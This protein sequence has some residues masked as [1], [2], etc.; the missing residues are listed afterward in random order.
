[1]SEA[2]DHLANRVATDPFF[3]AF[4][5]AEYARAEKLDD[6]AVAAAL[7]CRVEDLTP[8]RLCRAPRP[9][10]TDFRA[11]VGAI[12]GRFGIA[13]GKLAEVVRRGE[14]LSRLRVA[15][16]TTAEAGWVVAARDPEKKPPT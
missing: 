11:D 2:L 13:P 4:V 9:D 8:L 7:G 10:P 14:A 15:A 1:M 5:L 12:A 3:L 16:P 6:S